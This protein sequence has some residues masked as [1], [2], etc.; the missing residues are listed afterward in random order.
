MSSR[1]TY[2]FQ[3]S[4]LILKTIDAKLASNKNAMFSI[5]ETEMINLH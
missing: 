1:G 5:I 4:S 2:N 3:I